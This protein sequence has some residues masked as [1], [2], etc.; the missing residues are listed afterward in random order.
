M[1]GSKWESAQR[2]AKHSWYPRHQETLWTQLSNLP[3][4][5]DF[6]GLISVRKGRGRSGSLW[7]L[8]SIP[9]WHNLNTSCTVPL[10]CTWFCSVGKDHNSSW[11]CQG[12]AE[13]LLVARP[14]TEAVP[15]LHWWKYLRFWPIFCV[16]HNHCVDWELPKAKRTTQWLPQI[17]D[18]PSS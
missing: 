3:N 5:W 12:W 17:W 8:C 13:A 11:L 18:Q 1:M 6:P 4:I 9:A 15:K 7:N 10:K 2:R 14:L 16:V